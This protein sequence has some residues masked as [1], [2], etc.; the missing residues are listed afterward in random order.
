[1]PELK[2]LIFF[3][4]LWQR[5]P[6]YNPSVF[7]FSSVPLCNKTMPTKTV[8]SYKS[9]ISIAANKN[10][11]LSNLLY[12][13]FSFTTQNPLAHILISPQHRSQ[14]IYIIFYTDFIVCASR[15]S[16]LMKT[17]MVSYN[18]CSFSLNYIEYCFI[19]IRLYNQSRL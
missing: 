4:W 5:H 12:S 9:T 8:T 1:M 10:I 19:S 13:W 2:N 14:I 15:K 7:T 16:F 17:N 11:L 6:C 18:T 3:I